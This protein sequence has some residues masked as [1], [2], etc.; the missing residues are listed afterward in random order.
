MS[1][2]FKNIFNCIPALT[3]N[4]LFKFSLLYIAI[5][6]AFKTFH[7]IWILH[8]LKFYIKLKSE[9]KQIMMFESGN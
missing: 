3:T 9:L 1:L 6:L 8:F 4:I 2:E 7:V 5:H